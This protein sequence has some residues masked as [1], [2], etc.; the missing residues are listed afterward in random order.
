[1]IS[2]RSYIREEESTI[3]K[4]LWQ[5]AEGQQKQLGLCDMLDKQ[6]SCF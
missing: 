2:D 1:M 4:K 3:G 5:T 6:L